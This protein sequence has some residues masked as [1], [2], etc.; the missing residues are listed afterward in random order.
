MLSSQGQHHHLAD[1]RV[2]AVIRFTWHLESYGTG[3]ITMVTPEL[4]TWAA[5]YSFSGFVETEIVL[6]VA[7]QSLTFITK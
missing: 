2:E 6:G 4:N 3:Q 7:N 5:D 1:T